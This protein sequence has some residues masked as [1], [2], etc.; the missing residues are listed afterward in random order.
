MTDVT[1]DSKNPFNQPEYVRPAAIPNTIDEP[2][3]VGDIRA[4]KL[5]GVLF[6][7]G[8]FRWVVIKGDE[9]RGYRWTEVVPAKEGDCHAVTDTF[10]ISGTWRKLGEKDEFKRKVLNEWYFE[11]RPVKGCVVNHDLN[12]WALEPEDE[13]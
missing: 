10:A 1:K 12:A 6:S 9:R 11:K 13:E 7:D 3:R 4:M 5:A 8:V 2:P